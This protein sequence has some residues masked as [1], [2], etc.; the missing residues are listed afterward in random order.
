MTAIPTRADA[1]NTQ[2]SASKHERQKWRTGSRPRPPFMVRLCA[3]SSSAGGVCAANTVARTGNRL[4]QHERVGAGTA[5]D[6]R[7]AVIVAD[8]A[9]G[10]PVVAGTAVE[11]IHAGTAVE[12]VVGFAADQ[13]VV[14]EAAVQRVVAIVAE[15]R[16]RPSYPKIRARPPRRRHS[17]THIC[18]CRFAAGH[19]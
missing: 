15:R 8:R 1:M 9:R 18:R 3:R 17:Y 11:C 12:H 10:Q 6:L 14:A 16:S 7:L 19:S 4:P 5:P 2:R 13:R